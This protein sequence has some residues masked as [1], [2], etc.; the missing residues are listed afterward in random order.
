MIL[1]F[2]ACAQI[3]VER[4]PAILWTPVNTPEIGVVIRRLAFAFHA[5]AI[6]RASSGSLK[7]ATLII[8]K[9]GL[10]FVEIHLGDMTHFGF[11]IRLDHPLVRQL[12]LQKV[13]E[14]FALSFKTFDTSFTCGLAR[15]VLN[16]SATLGGIAGYFDVGANNSVG[17]WKTL[18][19]TQTQTTVS[20]VF[21]N[22]DGSWELS[23]FRKVS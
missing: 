3:C 5:A 1:T 13:F 7:Q 23:V 15:F 12:S 16:I 11:V 6:I 4:S 14:S 18:A 22:I 19:A 2:F 20:A 21:I 8:R 17:H 10:I 9:F